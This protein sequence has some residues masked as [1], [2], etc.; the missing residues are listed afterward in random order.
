MGLDLLRS[1]YPLKLLGCSRDLILSDLQTPSPLLV[2][3]WLPL[4]GAGR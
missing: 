1:P 2:T 3:A 4:L